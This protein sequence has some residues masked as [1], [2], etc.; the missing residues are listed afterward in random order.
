MRKHNAEVVRRDLAAPET[1]AQ[2]SLTGPMYA[3]ADTETV[4]GESGQF[5][6][7]GEPSQGV[8]DARRR[9]QPKL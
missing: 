7:L 8:R 4:G 9:P 3:V 2:T 1:A 6:E 5:R